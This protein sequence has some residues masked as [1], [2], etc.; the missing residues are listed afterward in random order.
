MVDGSGNG[1]VSVLV[2][3]GGSCGLYEIMVE[4]KAPAKFQDFISHDRKIKSPVP[5]RGGGGSVF[6]RALTSDI[7]LGVEAASEACE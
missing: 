3:L 1:G 6:L 2:E 7:N 4:N 5:K